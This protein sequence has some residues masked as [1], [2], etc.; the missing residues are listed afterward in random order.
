MTDGF[1]G[2]LDRISPAEL[3]ARTAD[4]GPMRVETRIDMSRLTDEQLALLAS[5]PIQ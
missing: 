4:G 3:H 5:V 1:A 2:G